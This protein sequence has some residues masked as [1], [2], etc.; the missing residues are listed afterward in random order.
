MSSNAVNNE[1]TLIINGVFSNGADDGTVYSRSPTSLTKL[2]SS[3][4][5]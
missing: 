5:H 2:I 4:L 1:A 3:Y